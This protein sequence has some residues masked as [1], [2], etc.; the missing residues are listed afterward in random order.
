L[1]LDEATSALDAQSEYVVQEALDRGKRD[2][3][4]LL[5]AHRL[6]T[7]EKADR[8][9][10]LVKGKVV[11]QGS[12]LQLMQQK[13]TYYDLVHRQLHCFDD[14]TQYSITDDGEGVL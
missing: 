3:T 12:H 4:V 13:G 14:S 2:R 10:V 1:L 9:V 8:I 7:V 6:S 5:V 11:E